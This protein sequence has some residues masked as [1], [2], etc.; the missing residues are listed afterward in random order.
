[1]NEEIVPFIKNNADFIKE[2][3][4][5][6]IQHKIDYIDAVVLYCEKHGIEIEVAASIIKNNGNIKSKIQAEA[7]TLNFL[8]RTSK[9][10]I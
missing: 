7:E 8:P 2:V 5:L 1:M 10:P 3:D 4:S 9:L 6:V